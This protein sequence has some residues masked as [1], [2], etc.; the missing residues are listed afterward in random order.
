MTYFIRDDFLQYFGG[1]LYFEMDFILQ[2]IK[3]LNKDL[4]KN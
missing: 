3:D 2:N 1:E 4:I